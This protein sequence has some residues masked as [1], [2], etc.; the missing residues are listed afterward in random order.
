[1]NNRFHLV[2]NKPA[3]AKCWTL[4]TRTDHTDNPAIFADT[5]TGRN[6][7]HQLCLSIRD[8]GWIECVKIV[9]LP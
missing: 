7:C 6:N 3:D 8:K 4:A 2:F 1:M 9:E 5:E